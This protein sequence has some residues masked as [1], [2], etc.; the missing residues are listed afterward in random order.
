MM[1]QVLVCYCIYILM[2]MNVPDEQE[3]VIFFLRKCHWVGFE[4]FKYQTLLFSGI[5]ANET[6]DQKVAC[7]L[8][9]GEEGWIRLIN[10]ESGMIVPN[11]R[12]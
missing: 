12:F 6:K 2:I 8:I 7:G 1:L 11:V 10:Q 5:N 9:E 4:Y 3:D